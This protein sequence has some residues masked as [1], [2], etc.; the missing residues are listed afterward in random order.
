VSATHDGIGYFGEPFRPDAGAFDTLPALIVHDTS[1]TEPQ[2]VLAERHVL[3][4]RP[5]PDGSRRVVELFV[6]A[7]RGSTTRI[8]A[9]DTQRPVWTGRIPKEVLEFEIGLSDMNED[10]IQR[11]GDTLA[12]FAAIPPGERQLLV[13]Y[14]VPRGVREFAIVVDQSVDR[15]A[16]LLEDSTSSVESDA[17]RLAGLGDLDGAVVRRFEGDSVE[18]GTSV[19][20]RFPSA[21]VS[22]SLMVWI[23]V[24]LAALGLLV[25]FLRWR[26]RQ[27]VGVDT[28][29]PA[30]PAQ[31]AAEIAALD[32][33]H[34]G[35]VTDEYRRKR[36]ELKERLQRVLA[37][38][39]V[40][41]GRDAS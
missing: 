15:F 14:L 9:E 10:A 20:V 37:D 31:L 26:S 3:V 34:A 23:V 6:L 19:R 27:P 33:T 17:V 13:G 40:D 22:G 32:R 29:V 1:S 24:P 39:G 38:R 4:R 18:P 5:E 11:S 41:V 36:A 7:N 2:I 30:D 28:R 16:V 25:T 35:N 12:V 8:A 21:G